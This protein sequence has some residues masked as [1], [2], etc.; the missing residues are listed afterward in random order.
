M[1]FMLVDFSFGLWL[2]NLIPFNDTKFN[3]LI[4]SND[5]DVDLE[6]ELCSL[7]TT[8][9]LVLVLEKLIFF[10][11]NYMEVDLDFGQ[12]SLIS[13]WRLYLIL[14]FV[15]FDDTKVGFDFGL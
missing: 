4:P 2:W 9:K 6:F 15:L 7:L 11:F 13:T 12:Y 1:N 14:E 5:M 10:P 3:N 8:W